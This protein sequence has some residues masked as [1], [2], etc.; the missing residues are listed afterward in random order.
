MCMVLSPSH[1]RDPLPR[2]PC[3]SS[4]GWSPA[5]SQ[6][7][8]QGS[9]SPP[10]TS[11]SGPGT[12]PP[13]SPKPVALQD[14]V[15]CIQGPTERPPGVP[16][17]VH[18]CVH[19]WISACTCVC[20]L[21]TSVRACASACKCVSIGVHM[22]MCVPCTHV[23]ACM[24]AY[25]CTIPPLAS[26]VWPGLGGTECG[27][28]VS[29]WPCP[30]PP[31]SSS[32]HPISFEASWGTGGG[33]R[34]CAAGAVTAGKAGSSLP[35]ARTSILRLRLPGGRGPGAGREGSVLSASWAVDVYAVII[36]PALHTPQPGI[37]PVKM[38]SFYG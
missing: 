37:K 7:S 4:P 17:C 11:P 23:R 12:A 29:N 2:T 26:R 10:R 35:L 3:G 8:S 6:P 20:I 18:V 5:H 24:C 19:V 25:V 22:L 9:L 21:C 34:G 16:V 27:L 30:A 15:S 33:G 14:G 13:V 36:A 31:A 28:H 1:P 38:Q 32:P